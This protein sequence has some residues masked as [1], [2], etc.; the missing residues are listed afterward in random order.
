MEKL[1]TIC[2]FTD[3]IIESLND[4]FSQDISVI[5]T[6][7]VGAVVDILKDLTEAEKNIRKSEYYHLICEAMK[8]GKTMPANVKPII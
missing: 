6:C 1:E 4:A 8:E 2:E 5:D 7:E 3:T